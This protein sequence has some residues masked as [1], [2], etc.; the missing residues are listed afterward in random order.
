MIVIFRSEQDAKLFNSEKELRKRF[1]AVNAKKIRRRL[2][3]LQSA[4]NLE[5][6]KTL[7]GK[8]HELRENRA[9]TFGISLEGLDRLIFEPA[10]DPVARK[11]DGGIDWTQTRTIR[12]LEVEDYHG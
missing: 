10:D 8:T 6:M 12:I 5:V 4:A 7:P 1:N 2:D 3:D 9:E 11:P